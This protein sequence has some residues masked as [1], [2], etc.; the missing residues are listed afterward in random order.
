M[1]DT[2][3]TATFGGADWVLG[4]AVNSAHDG[5]YL[6]DCVRSDETGETKVDPRDVRL[7]REMVEQIE[8]RLRET[9]GLRM[10]YGS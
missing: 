1:T 10:P 4:V 7:P 9:Y 3:Y 6:T 8:D 5:W 2:T